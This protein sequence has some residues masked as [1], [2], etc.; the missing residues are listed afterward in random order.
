MRKNAFTLVEL[1]VV[2]AIIGMLVG[3]LLPAVQQAREAART[4]QCS[5]NLKNIGLACLNHESGMR[6]FPSSGWTYTW[7][8]DADRSGKEQPGTWNYAILPYLEQNALYQCCSDGQPDTVTA[9][10][11]KG[12]VTLFDM[13]LSVY[14]CPSRRAAK[15]YPAQVS[16]TVVNSDAKVEKNTTSHPRSD[17]AGNYGCLD[18]TPY[19]N[20]SKPG[21]VTDLSPMRSW[22]QSQWEERGTENGVIYRRSAVKIGEIRDGTSNTYLAG[23]KYVQP[24]FYEAPGDAGDDSNMYDGTDDGSI[25]TGY[26]ASG[27]SSYVPL[28]DR[29]G[30]NWRFAFGSPHAGTLGMV[31][32]DGS[33]QRISYSIEPENHSYLCNRKDGKPVTLE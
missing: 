12:A 17:Y 23:E 8:G 25:R 5:N 32:C 4:M 10:Q 6:C 13:P 30:M 19:A 16:Y 7:T 3:L 1:L 18:A 27:S 33:V 31:M 2:I 26:Y 20:S 22:S 9:E 21:S 15:C 29:D 28:Q 11:K 24:Q 14:N